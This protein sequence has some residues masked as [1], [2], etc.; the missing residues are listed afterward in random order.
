MFKTAIIFSTLLIFSFAANNSQACMDH[1]FYDQG[2]YGALNKSKRFSS[3]NR[4]VVQK[5]VFQVRHTPAALATVDED[6]SLQISYKLPATAKNVSIEFTGTDNV[7]LLDQG[8]E[9]TE[10]NGTV[11][12][13]FRVL[14]QGVDT[15]TVTVKGENEG[16]QLSYSSSVYVNTKAAESAAASS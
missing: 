3:L 4:T 2:S 9:L 7:K 10:L 14:K 11:T 12:A 15:I 16:E 5:K 1:Y 13:R 8:V 6:A